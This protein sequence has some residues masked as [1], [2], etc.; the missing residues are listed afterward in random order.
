MKYFAVLCLAV[1]A[2]LGACSNHNQ[3][4]KT[5]QADSSARADSSANKNA[6][7][8]VADYL[9]AEILHV[10]SALLALK[11]FTTRDG[12]TDSVFIQLPEFN[13]LAL[14]F[15]PQELADGSF[16]KNFTENAFQDKATRTITFTY[17][18]VNKD[19]GLQRV[20]VI[21]VPGPRSQ[22]V[23]SIYL[24]KTRRSGDSVILQKM[25]WKAQQSFEIAT[26]VRVKGKQADEHQ[27]SVIWDTD[28]E[29]D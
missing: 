7:F 4:A 29:E 8:P 10:D 25:F 17:S 26:L 11:K 2:L 14:E 24:E 9:E 6:F 23:K 21:T 16:E 3:S 12:H 28:H 20:D 18:A 15:V 13:T 22:Q 27:V 1:T 5:S 19:A